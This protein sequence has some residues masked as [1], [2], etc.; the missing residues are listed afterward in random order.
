M[1][2][3]QLHNG[4]YTSDKDPDPR[5]E[6]LKAFDAA[7]ADGWGELTVIIRGGKVEILWSKSKVFE[8]RKNTPMK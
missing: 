3:T 4:A 5:Q 8:G 6:L 7:I 2:L 1:T